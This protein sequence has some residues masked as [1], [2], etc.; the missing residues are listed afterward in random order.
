MMNYLIIVKSNL[1]ID[2]ESLYLKHGMFIISL[3]YAYLILISVS[4]QYFLAKLSKI[5]H[6]PG[7]YSC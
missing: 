2:R 3:I 6:L 5:L 1:T 7:T 4:K